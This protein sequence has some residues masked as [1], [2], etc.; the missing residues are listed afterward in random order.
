MKKILWKLLW[1][2]GTI[3]VGG[4]WFVL[5]ALIGFGVNVAINMATKPTEP[6]LNT[7]LWV[8]IVCIGWAVLLVLSIVLWR[9]WI[10]KCQSCK[11]WGALEPIKT[12]LAKQEKISVLVEVE[13]RDLQRNVIGTQDQYIPG[14]RKIFTDTYKCKFCGHLETRTH[15]R[16]S[17]DL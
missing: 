15:T 17:A 13:R 16:E 12:E 14:K 6:S 11:R 4:L 5:V 7:N 1:I 9:R 2:A 3:I 10:F 8:I